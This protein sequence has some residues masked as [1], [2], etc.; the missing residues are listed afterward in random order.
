[1][2]TCSTRAAGISERWTRVLGAILM[3]ALM[4][5]VTVMAQLPSN[6]SPVNLGTAGNFVVLAQTGIST[7]GTTHITGDIGIS[8]AA[9]TF[10]TGF[11]LIADATNQFSTSSYIT[12][13]AYAA[14]YAV[15]TPAKMTTAIGDMGTAFTDA[16]GRAPDSIE[17]GAGNI[18]G[19]T[20]TRGV[21]KWSTGLTISA[22]GV[23]LSGSATDV[24]IFQ[25]AGNLTVANAAHVNLSGG[26]QASNIFWK[27][28]GNTS[29]GTTAAMSGVILCQTQ[30][31]LSTGASFNGR[32]LA[33]TAVT[34]D[35]NAITDPGTSSPPSNIP[36][37]TGI[38]LPT[39]NRGSVGVKVTITGS[40]FATGVTS[41]D[42][43]AGVTVNSIVV[44]SPTSITA[45]ITLASAATAGTRTVTVTNSGSGGG[46][47]TLPSGFTVGT[48]TATFVE[49]VSSSVPSA[50]ELDQNYP[51]PFNPSTRIQYSLA[52]ATQVSLKVYNLIGN[53]V[54]TL[55]NDYQEAGSYSVPFSSSRETF[56]LSSG[57]YF[58]RLEAGSFVSTKKLILVK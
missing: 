32:A 55:V 36:T 8:P 56:D 33:Q 51:N 47:A 7:T 23:T 4:V 37:I 42:F 44:N 35:A 21:Y 45:N 20:L 9:A 30:I 22:G 29:L 58:Y 50:F 41:V 48:G 10:M 15:P 17:V 19:K 40:N 13:R 28:S 2:K 39:V 16:A 31:A 43:G 11:G 25:I 38:S 57:V 1:M 34:L 46:S 52:K 6:P 49:Q 27:V 14:N 5:P 26:A 54:A 24:W 3:V 18:T 53:V 12:G